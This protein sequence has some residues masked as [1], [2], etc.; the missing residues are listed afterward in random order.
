MNLGEA[1]IK[2]I[3]HI[4]EYS[5]NGSV[6]S[7]GQNADYTN[8]FAVHANDAQME[9]ADKIGIEASY[10]F[11]QTASSEEG[12][13]KYPL[14]DDFK[15]FL[16]LN[17]SDEPFTAFRIENKNILLRK[18]VEGDFELLYYKN[19]AE[20][21]DDTPD[22]HT[23]EIDAQYHSLIPYYMGGMAVIDESPALSDKLL[24]LYYS[25]LSNAQ[26]KQED[27]PTTIQNVYWG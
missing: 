2:A 7:A 12:Y 20:I 13:E 6:T 18:A 5:T 27:Y 15:E 4:N 16:R 24:N 14:P 17:R 1:K 22:D 23:F 19:P 8:R 26:K 3:K 9:I 25:R 21:K 10:T 11:S